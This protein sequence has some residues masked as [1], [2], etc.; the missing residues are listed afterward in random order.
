MNVMVW[1]VACNLTVTECKVK[2]VASYPC[3]L[4]DVHVYK[5]WY[6]Y[7]LLALSHFF[8]SNNVDIWKHLWGHEVFHYVRMYVRKVNK[9]GRPMFNPFYAHIFRKSIFQDNYSTLS[10]SVSLLMNRFTADCQQIQFHTHKHSTKESN[11][12]IQ[13][14]QT[15]NQATR[16]TLG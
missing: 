1:D 10:I 7:R 6:I 15:F 8:T 2:I 13:I 5:K 4:H 14:Y 12:Q 16:L 11:I 9:G 3:R